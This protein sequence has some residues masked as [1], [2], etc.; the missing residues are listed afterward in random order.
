MDAMIAVMNQV[1]EIS[2]KLDQDSLSS[3][4][5]RNL[6]RLAHIFEE[7]GYTWNNPLGEKYTDA[8]TDCT[9]SIAGDEGRDM[10]ITQVIK[11]VI[12]QK[13]EGTLSLVQKGIVIVERKK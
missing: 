5:E 8:R 6:N 13:K 2:Q 3:R 4:F 7:E 10:V 12:Y 1:F 9:A 11:P